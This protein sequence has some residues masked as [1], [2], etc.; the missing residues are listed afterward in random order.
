MADLTQLEQLVTQILNNLNLI[1][2]NSKSVEEL[3]F[4]EVLNPNSKIPA[5]LPGNLQ[6]ITVQQLITAISNYNYNR[7]ISVGA[8]SI[9]ELTNELTIEATVEAVINNVTVQKIT[10]ST[11]PITL[12]ASGLIRKDLFYINSSGQVLVTSGDEGVIA[13]TPILPLNAVYIT[14]IIVTDSEIGAPSDPIVGDEFVKKIFSSKYNFNSSGEDKKIPF[15]PNGASYFVLKNPLLESVTGFTFDELVGLDVQFPYEGKDIF[16]KNETGV[17]VTIKHDYVLDTEITLL[18]KDNIDTEIPNNGIIWLKFRNV[19]V[20]EIYRSWET[21]GSVA[22][23]DITGSV[24][25]NVA[26]AAALALKANLSDVYTKTEI[27]AKIS[28]VFIYK[29]S[30]ANYAALTALTG[31]EVGWTYNLTDTGDNYAWDGTY[32]DKLSG[33]VD[34]S[35]KEDISNKKT[36]LEANKTSNT[37]Y[38]SC[39]AIVDWIVARYQQILVSGTNIKTFYGK[40][41]LGSGEIIEIKTITGNTTIDNSYNGALVKTKANAVITL[42]AGLVS[43]FNF[44]NRHYDGTTVSYVAGAGVTI[45]AESDETNFTGK[46]MVSIFNDGADNYIICGG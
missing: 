2:T 4:Q 24:A 42:Q 38:A 23:A 25:D 40:S 15:Q 30:V 13:T 46:S 1:E 27:D 8:I 21:A 5:S 34:I 29:G 31:Q 16:I 6:H 28:A 18:L 32:W 9:D 22:F 3:P 36:D 41:L 11:F 43:P 45:D 37:F 44:V 17:S 33:V 14:D 39:K 26:L 20:E 10:D 7:L 35:G 19:E 12:A